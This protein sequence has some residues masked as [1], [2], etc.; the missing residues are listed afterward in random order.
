MTKMRSLIAAAAVLAAGMV[1]LL[2]SHREPREAAAQS[3][4]NLTAVAKITN[5]ARVPGTVTAAGPRNEFGRGVFCTF[6][7]S[8]EAG[9]PSTVIS[10]EAQDATSSQ[11]QALGAAG[12]VTAIGGQASIIVYPG[13]VATSVP[14][15]LTVVGLKV[16]ALWRL[17]QVITGGTTSTGSASCDLLN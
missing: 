9:T 11:W 4:G 10:V 14:S 2:S 5:T 17:V 12:A 7:Q 16:P 13:A 3:V 1:L 15:G 8:A 6:Y